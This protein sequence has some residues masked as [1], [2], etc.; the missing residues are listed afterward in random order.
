MVYAVIYGEY[1]SYPYSASYLQPQEDGEQKQVKVET[2]Q[3]HSDVSCSAGLCT[4]EEHYT[5]PLNKS[6]LKVLSD[7]YEELSL[8]DRAQAMRILR[9][10]EGLLHFS[11][12]IS[13]LVGLYRMVEAH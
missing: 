3:I 2:K 12:N 7:N 9:K 10:E 1:R 5:F 13:E 11:L 8:T 4:H 6:Y